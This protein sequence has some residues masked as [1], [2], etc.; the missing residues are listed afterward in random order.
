MSADHATCTATATATA[1]RPACGL[2]IHVP[3]CSV[4]CPF[5]NF[6]V[7]TAREDVDRWLEAVE[8]ELGLRAPDWPQAFDTVYFGGG[9]PSLLPARTIER[10]LSEVRG[11]LALTGDAEVTIEVN[12]GDLAESDLARLRAAGVNRL[13][14][15]VQ[16]LD[17]GDL[18]FLGRPHDAVT[19]RET[20]AA[21]RRA[22]FANISVDL[23]YGLPLRARGDW[24]RQIDETG[25]L[26]PE[27]I[28]AYTL[29]WEP[30]T[31]L[32]RR[33]DAGE[34]PEPTEAETRELFLFTR[35]RLA[36]AGYEQYEVSSFARAE[37]FRSR[38]N[39]KYWD[40]N[41]YLG[42]GPAAH[43]WRDGRR[44][45]NAP[46][47]RD[48]ARRVLEGGSPVAGEEALSSDQRRLERLFLGL[49]TTGGVDLDA[50]RRDF[51]TDLVT[52]RYELIAGLVRD[53]EATV[54]GAR[55]TLT[56]TGLA[57][58]DAIAVALS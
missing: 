34:F 16:S 27:H 42:I 37:R 3:F 13:S 19:A 38:H 54:T 28:S 55:L 47:V 51:D 35:D 58:A 15:G 12:P 45:W 53:G 33:R 10:L 2:Y 26:G 56:P 49:R 1:T 8:R 7:T 29:T 4:R 44:W 17:D 5:C 57:I 20:F 14:L 40:E 18:R 21:A 41:A 52:E 30:G 46:G 6:A 39:S 32:T 50:F 9:T 43:S 31:P 48:Y 11:L 23:I 24:A 25:R 36:R 22:G